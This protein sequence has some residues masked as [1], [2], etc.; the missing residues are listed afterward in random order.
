MDVFAS[1]RPAKAVFVPMVAELPTW[2]NTLQTLAPFR[3]STLAPLAVVS[4]LPIWKMKT[5]RGSPC[6]S[7]VS[8]PVSCADDVKQ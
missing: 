3:T 1:I 4:V 7:S 6:A 5:L 8:A 2:K